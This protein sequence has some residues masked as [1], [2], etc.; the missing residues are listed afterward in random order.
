V[1]ETTK[2][3]THYQ[4]VCAQAKLQVSPDYGSSP[5]L[6]DLRL[7]MAAASRVLDREHRSKPVLQQC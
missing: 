2:R 6:K 7:E 4:V 5:S 1:A 3:P